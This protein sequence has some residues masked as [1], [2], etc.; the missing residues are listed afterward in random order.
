M[1]IQT[2]AAKELQLEMIAG[3]GR[4]SARKRVVTGGDMWRPNLKRPV[5]FSDLMRV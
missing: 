1:T 4:I 3:P 2:L 5:L